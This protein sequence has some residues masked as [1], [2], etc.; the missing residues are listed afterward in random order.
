MAKK[1]HAPRILEFFLQRLASS[2]NNESLAGD[3]AEIYDRI[4]NEKSRAKALWWYFF[5][6][7]KLIPSSIENQI[8]W[9]MDMILSYSKITF[10]KFLRHKGFSFINISGLAI[11]LAC[12][13][14][15]LLWVQHELSYDGFHANADRIYRIILNYGEKDS[16]GPHGPGALGPALKEEYSEIVDSTRFFSVNK[17]PVRYK[18]KVLNGSVCG[19]DP[20][21]LKIFT[22][23]FVWGDP[24]KAMLDNNS[25]VLTETMVRR[26]FGQKDPRGETLGFE[27]WGRWYDFK[28]TGVVKDTPS[29]SHIKFDYILPISFVTLSGMDIET[30]NVTAY[31][32]YVL[33]NEHADEEA[34]GKKIAGILQRHL[35]ESTYTVHMEAVS[36]IH[37]YNYSGG[38][39][40]TY[41]YLFGIIGLFILGIACINFMNLSTARSADR[42][43]E[44]GIRKIVGS[45]RSQL[46]KQFL[47]ESVVMAYVA[48]C[49]ALV[50]VKIFLPYISKITDTRLEMRIYGPQLMIFLGIALL[51]GLLSG[52]Y[53]ALY[54]S[55]V[56][57]A[58][59]LKGSHRS[60]GRNLL[61]CR[62]LVIA[63]FAISILLILGTV[64]TYE[65]LI[66]LRS[67][68]LGFDKECIVNFE[69]RGGLRSNYSTI[70]QELLNNPNI[71]AVCT[72]NGSFFRR[73]ATDEAVWHGKKEDER[74]VMAIHSVDF[75]Y[76]KVFGL[77]MLQGRY[78]SEEFTTDVSE[79]IIVNET[80]VK[81]MGLEEPI[82]TRFYCPMPF[83]MSKDGKI[84]GVVKD[85][86]FCSLYRKIEPLILGIAPGWHTDMYVKM[87][88]QDLPATLAHIQKTFRTFAS[89]FPFEFSFLDE[90]I[91][92]LYKSDVRLGSLV[93]YGALVAI[94]IACLGLFGLASFTAAQ[95][96][97]EIGIR[98][99][100]GASIS[101]IT[102][103]LTK[104][105]TRW[106][107]AANIIAWPI[108]YL[109]M[110]KWLENF[111]YRID[112]PIWAFVFSGLLVLGLS[113]LTVCHQAIKAA[114]AAPADL[115][116]YE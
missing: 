12:A 107:L 3:F 109:V 15:I 90:N 14:I 18:D 10:R 17:N 37:L 110:K 93:K 26:I 7:L 25:I 76:V 75:D 74:I 68:D 45:H 112:I 99:V 54:L 65:Q 40:I 105:F 58:K 59:V 38:G 36:R 72:T 16:F 23:P 80:A 24:D 20:S 116:R 44:V 29:N 61:L 46:I 113:L 60:G 115:L 22:F 111:A 30:W 5:H 39:P 96:T 2:Q 66:Y 32:T 114:L 88:S 71:I 48:L 83:D 41:I 69:L 57:P 84:I 103:L 1:K 77:Q 49:F 56:L 104:E 106:V 97:K 33:L 52:S 42:A 63:Q 64:I 9:N 100:L 50:L 79:G 55:R 11:G 67:K 70:K 31:H 98:K 51:A 85:F 108:G 81:M 19:V 91:D 94:F 47:S 53:P 62:Y 21:F 13:I 92:S 28:V 6:I 82:G 4:L 27:W 86:H 78:F 87:R 34:L 73:F 43:L 89:D 8:F 102:V 101:N 35:P 95:R